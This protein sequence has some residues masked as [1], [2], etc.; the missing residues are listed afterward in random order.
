MSGYSPE[1]SLLLACLRPSAVG[2]QPTRGVSGSLD[3]ERFLDL[4]SWHR[5]SGLVHEAMSPRGGPVEMPEWVSAR[6]ERRYERAARRAIRLN[7]ELGRVLSALVDRGIEVVLLKGAAL[8]HTVYAD[9]A[10]RPMGDLDL[11]VPEDRLD[12]AER[13]VLGL[14]YEF[15]DSPEAR[16][17]AREKHRHYPRLTKEEGRYAVEL[18]RHIVE[19][20]SPLNFDVAELWSSARP[21]PPDG[22]RLRVLSA[23]DQLVHLSTLR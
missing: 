5:V 16:A 2:S 10:L 13:V 19:K 14:G 1:I 23:E 21:V 9:P 8:V 20:G 7:H 15:F 12:D 17:L 22:S 18:H 6:L 11:L 3:W 4:C